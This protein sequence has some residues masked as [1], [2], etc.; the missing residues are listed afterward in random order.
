MT[1]DCSN[2]LSFELYCDTGVIYLASGVSEV[3]PLRQAGWTCTYL[4]HYNYIYIY[5]LSSSNGGNASLCLCC[6]GGFFRLL[7]KCIADAAVEEEIAAA[8]GNR[9][10]MT[11][12]KRRD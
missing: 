1:I 9:G 12:E 4:L 2:I 3:R 11:W 5:T 10:T 6:V 8:S 7:F